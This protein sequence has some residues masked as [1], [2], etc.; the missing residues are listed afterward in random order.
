MTY[1]LDKDT[2]TSIDRR[3]E[4]TNLLQE[5]EDYTYFTL[6]NDDKYEIRRLVERIKRIF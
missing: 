2:L 6:E 4:I 1:N 3:K 5:I